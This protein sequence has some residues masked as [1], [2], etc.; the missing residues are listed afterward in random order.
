[1]AI[2]I[3]ALMAA[4]AVDR[5]PTGVDRVAKARQLASDIRLTQSYAMSRG[6]NF[7]ILA[8][9][10][11]GYEIRQSGDS[12]PF[13][14]HTTTVTNVTFSSFDIAFDQLGQPT[15]GAAS[16]NVTS[17]SG[18]STVRVLAVTGLVQAP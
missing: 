15:G 13:H 10:L 9:G 18:V 1:M 8:T 6:V 12:T 7:R 3:M 11:Y 5:T 4:S 17:G 14:G 16:I 2:V